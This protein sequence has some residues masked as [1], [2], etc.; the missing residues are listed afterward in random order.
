[1]RDILCIFNN[2]FIKWSYYENIIW[3]GYKEFDNL[4]NFK[5]LRYLVMNC[6][7]VFCK[8]FGYFFNKEWIFFMI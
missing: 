1:M 5:Y 7:F 6:R 4:L 8:S 2:Y 3:V